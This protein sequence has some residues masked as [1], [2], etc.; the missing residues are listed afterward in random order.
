MEE[1]IFME[2]NSNLLILT[3]SDFE[4]L[5]SL[6]EAAQPDI[7]EL[8]KEELSRAEIVANDE[9]PVDVVSM[10][11]KVIFKDLVTDKE[12]VV[13]LVYPQDANID[14]GKI[15]IFAP[16]GSA[17]IGLRVGQVIN[18]PLPNGKEKRIQVVS[19]SSISIQP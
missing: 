10:N 17:L 5:N 16:V 11:S 8:L 18:W 19:V 15:S 2:N 6:L 7:A 3:Q 4:K 9:L 1:R 13:T 14:E 12:S